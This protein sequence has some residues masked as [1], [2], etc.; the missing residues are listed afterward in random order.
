MPLRHLLY[1]CPGCGADPTTG[2]ADRVRCP[3]CGTTYER[4]PAAAGEAN[5]AEGRTGEGRRRRSA[6]ELVDALRERGGPVTPA[7]DD[8]GGLRWEARA[9][10]R[11]AVEETPVRHGAGLLGFAE[12]FGPPV[13]GRLLLTGEAVRFEGRSGEGGSP[14]ASWRWELQ[15]LGSLQTSSKAVQLRPPSG[16]VVSFRFPDDSPRRWETLLEH[17]LREAYREAGRGEIVE[18]QPR[19]V[20]RGV[21][22]GEVEDGTDASGA[23]DALPG[24]PGPGP[25]ESRG[26]TAWYRGGKILARAL[27]GV[28]GGA[29]VRGRENI[30]RRGPFVLVANHVSYLDPIFIQAVCP[31]TVHSMTKSTQYASGFFRWLLPRIHTFPVRRYRVDAQSV[32]IVLRKLAAG[33]G[34]GI[35]PE[36][37]RSWDGRLQAFRLGSVRVLLRAGVP[38]IPCGISGSYALWPRWSGRIVRT[39]LR[40]RFGDPLDLGGPLVDRRA[41]EEALPGA[42][43]RLR[44][45][46]EALLV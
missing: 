15:E 6:P 27:L 44:E 21:R 26:T 41:R 36:G 23:R 20:T 24:L 46:L 8:G 31:R 19:I 7:T 42:T 17:A 35:Y 40:I 33:R 30:P 39:R 12:R 13:E 45:A 2:E 1:R 43:R 16:G 18:F 34:V 14:S 3:S 38:V 9:V 5:I 10:A 32:R 22:G 29:D 37:E 11:R 25:G 4:V 28:V